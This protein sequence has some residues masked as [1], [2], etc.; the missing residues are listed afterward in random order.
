VGLFILIA[1]MIGAATGIIYAL[2]NK[3]Q[4]QKIA[5]TPD[6]PEKGNK[7][8]D[9][10]VP[11]APKQATEGPKVI[12]AK[13]PVQFPRRLL[14]ISVN[15][16]LYANPISYGTDLDKT[17]KDGDK[18]DFGRT[19][20]RLEVGL[21]IP[22]DQVYELS[23]G[24]T[25]ADMRPPLKTVIEQTAT[26][27]LETCRPQDRIIVIFVG[28]SLEIEGKPYLVP[29]EG[30]LEDAKTLIPLEWLMQQLDKCRAQ[31]KWLIADLNR[32]DPSRGFERPSGGKLSAAVEAM[33]KN[34]PLGVEVWSACSTGQYSHEFDDYRRFQDVDIKGGAFLN[35]FFHAFGSGKGGIS[36]PDDPLPIRRLAQDVNQL[37][38]AMFPQA[39]PDQKSKASGTDEQTP[40][41]S[42]ELKGD[43]IPFIEDEP[44]PKRFAIPTPAEVF[45]KGLAGKAEVAALLDEIAVPP[46]RPV[47]ATGAELRFDSVVPFT[48]DVMK[49]YASDYQSLAEIRKMEEMFPLRVATIKAIE[50]LRDLG[51]SSKIVLPDELQNPASEQFKITLKNLQKGPARIM[52]ELQETMEMLEKAGEDR[53]EEKSKRWQAH[54]D[55]VL[56]QVKL[57]LVATHQYS[58][59]TGQIR[60]DALPELPREKNASWGWRLAASETLHPETNGEIKGYLTESRKLMTKLI[61]NNPG[62]PWEVLARREQKTALGLEWVPTNFRLDK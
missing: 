56:A 15:N 34:P 29:L 11:E 36:R 9:V 20:R 1:G 54:Y 40:F 17:T 31:Q 30:D 2:K 6:Q 8:D 43:S 50:K 14:G 5:K 51:K 44:L 45:D 61:K 42:G 60:R 12:P 41:L 19:L 49:A 46:I 4:I 28:H 38:R 24:A 18:H 7:G 27:F 32:Y 23:D 55:Y 62:T 13:P 53:K 26:R 47:R 21:K 57:K 25:G 16:Y 3:E 22:A 58:L 39:K 52:D 10:L 37:T 48:A 35:F 59:M 33:L